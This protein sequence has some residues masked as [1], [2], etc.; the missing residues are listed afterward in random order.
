MFGTQFNVSSYYSILGRSCSEQ[1]S[2]FAFFSENKHHLYMWLYR[3]NDSQ[4]ASR[5]LYN[6]G[7]AHQHHDLQD[8][9]MLQIVSPRIWFPSMQLVWGILTFW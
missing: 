2:N 7:N 9:L 1:P 4:C 8:N 5:L 3:W 6:V